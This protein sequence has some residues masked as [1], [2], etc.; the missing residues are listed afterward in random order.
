MLGVVL[1]LFVLWLN[2]KYVLDDLIVLGLILW[3][4]CNLVELLSFI[5]LVWDVI[6]LVLFLLLVRLYI[7]CVVLVDEV[8]EILMLMF[9]DFIYS[10]DNLWVV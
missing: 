10:W 4:D 7:V 9:V 1:I 8:V 3:W 2:D 6:V 5:I